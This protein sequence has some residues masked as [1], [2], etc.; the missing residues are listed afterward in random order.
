ML[1]SM[2]KDY[3]TELKITK[4]D[5]LDPNYKENIS[6]RMTTK[7]MCKF[8]TNDPYYIT[9]DDAANVISLLVPGVDPY[10]SK[11]YINKYITERDIE[12]AKARFESLKTKLNVSS[13]TDPTKAFAYA[14][15]Y[16][17]TD[18]Y[19]DKCKN[20]SD[21]YNAV[22][23]ISDIT[24]LE[25]RVCYTLFFNKILNKPNEKLDC[26]YFYRNYTS[27]NIPE[28]ELQKCHFYEWSGEYYKTIIK[29]LDKYRDEII[30]KM[31]HSA[32]KKES[33]LIDLNMIA[34]TLTDMSVSKLKAT[35]PYC[36]KVHSSHSSGWAQDATEITIHYY[37][38][39]LSKKE[40]TAILKENNV[41]TKDTHERYSNGVSYNLE[42]GGEAIAND[43]NSF[44][45]VLSNSIKDF[46]PGDEFEYSSYTA[47]TNYHR[48]VHV[49]A[50]PN[51]NFIDDKTYKLMDRPGKLF[52]PKNREKC[53]NYTIN[54]KVESKNKYDNYY[55]GIDYAKLDD[56]DYP[57]SISYEEFL[58]LL[59]SNPSSCSL[60]FGAYIKDDNTEYLQ[61]MQYIDTI[62]KYIPDFDVRSY[63]PNVQYIRYSYFKADFN[64]KN[65][66]D[67]IDTFSQGVPITIPSDNK[68]Y[69]IYKQEND[70]VYLM[71]YKEIFNEYVNTICITKEVFNKIFEE[72]K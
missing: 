58:D 20:T 29:V 60:R 71:E 62:T 23:N 42:W 10:R 3:L 5:I 39:N 24:A 49:I 7:N 19:T 18:D 35:Y 28:I 21:L 67:F 45:Y 59:Q 50:K 61:Y 16:Y 46:T 68:I 56:N 27:S 52:I 12:K 38:T 36:A 17:T 26:F 33:K 57:S 44:S 53:I 69:S 11:D 55:S 51:N 64:L 47:G 1:D 72:C 43:Y 31:E 54:G 25:V 6:K 48:Y 70:K 13:I 22:K 40:I 66:N 2:A 37:F 8:L 15:V 63:F 14:Y 34:D 4:K 41:N 30:D 32:A 65:I 9:K